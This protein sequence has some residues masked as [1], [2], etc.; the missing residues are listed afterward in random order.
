MES[1]LQGLLL[2]VIFPVP[3][4]T[5]TRAIA[6]LRPPNAFTTSIISYLYTN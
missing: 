4:V 1:T 2:I 6:R 5:N 3:S